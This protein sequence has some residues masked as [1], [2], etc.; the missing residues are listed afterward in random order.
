ML[1]TFRTLILGSQARAKDHVKD[2]FAIELIDQHVRETENGLSRAKVVLAQMIQRERTDT[3]ILSKLGT[4]RKDLETRIKA[5][6]AD[7]N[8]SLA[9]E[10]AQALAHM[11]N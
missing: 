1:G 4:D 11:E 3:R 5:A 10:A 9:Q 7:G 2:V 8:D 6:L